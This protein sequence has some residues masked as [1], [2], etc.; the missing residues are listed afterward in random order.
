MANDPDDLDLEILGLLSRDGRIP[1]AQIA[2]EVG[3]SRPAVGQRIERLEKSGVLRGVTAVVDPVAI[4]RPIT[5]FVFA[6]EM[7]QTGKGRPAAL[8]DLLAKGD[9]LEMHS[10][11]GDD[12][13]LLKI[14]TDSIASLNTLVNKLGSPPLGM[15]TRT[16]IVM[17]THYEKVGGILLGG[18]E[19]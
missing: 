7:P 6:R 2:G 17:Q 8:R 4:G 9:V 11:A 12:C 15:S 5:A 3:L 14:R 19:R 16:T 10:V 13:Y 1:L 18:T